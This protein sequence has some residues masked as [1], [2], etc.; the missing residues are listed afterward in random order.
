MATI[1]A[2]QLANGSKRYRVRYRTPGHKQTA[3]RG[4]KTKREA[5]LFAAT[6]E[7]A[8][9]QGQFIADSAG[10]TLVGD[11]VRLWRAGRSDLTPSTAERYD[12]IV[13]RHIAPKWDGVTLGNLRHSDVQN[14]VSSLVV[15]GSSPATARKVHR[16][17]SLALDLAV[18]DRRL[19]VNPAAGIKIAQPAV[20]T[21]RY[22]THSQVAQLAAACGSRGRVV[23]VTLAYCGLRWGELAALKVGSIDLSRARL[24]VASSVTEVS[25]KLQWGDPKTHQHRTVPIPAFLVVE[26]TAHL[27]GRLA[28]DLAFP[29]IGGGVL[30][31]RAARNSWFDGA[32]VTSGCP[33]GL[34]PHE[35]RH[36]AASLAISAGANI[37]AV[38]RMLG[39]KSA[40]MTLDT[41]AD[42]FPDDLDAVGIALNQAALASSVSK[43][44]PRE[45][46]SPAS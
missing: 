34:H 1:E 2:Y 21:R 12:G 6:V 38:Q 35:L 25:G 46:E 22:L 17:L 3:K 43:V 44:C 19:S 5:D 33:D 18:R 28:D 9:A 26:L 13:R 11:W 31:Y 23:V 41:Y 30:R 15:T 39:H 16:V 4:F 40:A 14:W 42:L 20:A 7:V 37:K 27:S 8:K 36:T 29:A 10:R 32:V 45:Q 24:T